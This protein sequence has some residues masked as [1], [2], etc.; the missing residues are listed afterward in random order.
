MH[1]RI[2]KDIEKACENM[3]SKSAH[4]RESL[5]KVGLQWR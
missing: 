1:L 4:N 2:Y 3:T 5:T